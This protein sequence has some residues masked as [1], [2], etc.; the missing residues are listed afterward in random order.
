VQTE[1][2]IRSIVRDELERREM[3]ERWKRVR[4]IGNGM[5]IAILLEGL[6]ISAL[7]LWRG[8]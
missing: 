7:I 1:A 2:D 4:R 8:I 5:V 6:I 3:Q